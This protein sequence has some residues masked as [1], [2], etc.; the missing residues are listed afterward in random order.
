LLK[1]LP[2]FRTVQGQ[3]ASATQLETHAATRGKLLVVGEEADEGT[4]GDGR[5]I[6][7]ASDAQLLALGDLLG[8]QRFERHDEAWAEELAGQRRRRETPRTRPAVDGAAVALTY[9][10]VGP[11]SG[12]GGLLN[13]GPDPKDDPGSLVEL[14]IDRRKVATRKPR[15]RM[16]V[17]VWVNDDRLQPDV[18]FRDVV[19]DAVYAEVMAAA[20]GQIPELVARAAERWE[21]RWEDE[22]DDP[23]R[24]RICVY[25]LAHLDEVRAGAR[26]GRRSPEQRLLRAPLWACVTATKGT[27]LV[28]TERLLEAHEAGRLVTADPSGSSDAGRPQDPQVLLL[29]ANAREHARVATT[30]GELR[31][32]TQQLQRDEAHRAFLGRK[33]HRRVD[34]DAIEH[35]P[36]QRLVWRAA[37]TEA[38]WEGELGLLADPGGP[39]MVHIFVE[40]R[41]LVVHQVD[42][43]VAAV[44]AVQHAGLTPDDTFSDVRRDDAFDAWFAAL[45][46]AVLAALEQ[47]AAAEPGDR[48]EAAVLLRALVTLERRENARGLV[49]R[50][51]VRPLLS[52]TA[53]R[54]WSVTALREKAA[55]HESVAC[56]FPETAA[57]TR[58][59][60]DQLVL[61]LDNTDYLLLSKLVPLLRVD[62]GY[63]AAAEARLRMEQAPTSAEVAWSSTVARAEVAHAE[64]GLRGELGLTVPPVQGQ[65][66][67]LADRRVVEQ[68]LF[69][70]MPGLVGYLDG[71]LVPDREFRQVEL[72][73]AHREA[74]A[75]LYEERLQQAVLEAEGLDA[76]ARKSARGRALS[77]YVLLYLHHAIR[78][79]GG[80]QY[81]RRERILARLDLPAPLLRALDLKVF[82]LHDGRWTDLATL[83][84][85]EDPLVVLCESSKVSDPGDSAVSL[86]IGDQQLMHPLLDSVL[87]QRSVV[88]YDRWRGKDRKQKK[89]QKEEDKRPG[90]DAA[91]TRVLHG[92]RS[93]LRDA[94]GRAEGSPLSLPLLGRIQA[95]NLGRAWGLGAVERSNDKVKRLLINADH[96]AYRAT[97]RAAAG[98]GPT[99]M[100]HLAAAYIA[101]LARLDPPLLTC[102][103]ALAL[104]GR[105]AEH[106]ATRSH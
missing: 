56:V 64:L 93:A 54:R 77:F 58:Y 71:D 103:Q 90:A 38:G 81:K 32:Y 78:H 9:F 69:N 75:C 59:D 30:L 46:Q 99:P 102:D 65:L 106:A 34:L 7:R 4:P 42:G 85:G 49:E 33:R 3:P 53:G 18:S 41:P 31:D 40:N 70:G 21:D 87:G 48:G 8:D 2:L 52:D 60:G 89:K 73:T 6:V 51:L 1:E 11:T 45:R 50:L 26:G 98:S 57:R 43:P 100:L 94:I 13:R 74:I 35:A 101:D 96:P 92:L 47:I 95:K 20:Q 36:D 44:C 12:L 76:R 25:L 68:R 24:R 29:W 5:L 23:L 97:A 37:L 83:I 63:T 15:W 19:E 14:H 39:M 27:H 86:V 84:S 62:A 17:H 66:A 10:H 22:P 80:N 82:E 91:S 105:L 79:L 72:T 55:T 104:L 28:D 88:S 67:L 61:I 16:P